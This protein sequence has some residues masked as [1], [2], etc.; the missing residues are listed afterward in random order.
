MTDLIITK[1][2]GFFYESGSFTYFIK[3]KDIKSIYY[4]NYGICIR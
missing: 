2:H 1:Q 3:Y 4:N